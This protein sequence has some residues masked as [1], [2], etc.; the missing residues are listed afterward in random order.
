[1]KA[2]IVKYLGPTNSL[3]SR[4]KASDMDGNSVVVPRDHSLGHD[5]LRIDAAKKLC[6]K[7]GWKGT[8]AH[9]FLKND[10]VF[11]F[12]DELNQIEVK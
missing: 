3:G 7:M 11:V 9:G 6:K 12:V 1:M 10:Y 2:I 5:E 8:L 4:L